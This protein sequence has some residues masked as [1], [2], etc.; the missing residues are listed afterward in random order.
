MRTPVV[1]TGTMLTGQRDARITRD[2][3]GDGLADRSE[4]L[5]PRAPSTRT[6]RSTPT[7]TRR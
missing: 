4:Q 6:T 3:D 2:R 7:A 1:A 5:A